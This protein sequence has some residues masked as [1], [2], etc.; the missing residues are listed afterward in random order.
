MKQR[1]RATPRFRLGMIPAFPSVLPGY[2]RKNSAILSALFFQQNLRDPGRKKKA[3]TLKNK[4]AF[5]TRTGL[6]IGRCAA[7]LFAG[8]RARIVATEADIGGLEDTAFPL[9]KLG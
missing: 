2:D 5:I 1:R 6:G 8:E 4:P 3:L 9:S 7:P